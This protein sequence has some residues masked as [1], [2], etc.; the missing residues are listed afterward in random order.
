MKGRNWKNILLVSAFF[1]GKV[2]DN[3]MKSYYITGEIL[4]AA[5]H[6][7]RIETVQLPGQRD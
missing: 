7:Q 4:N 1:N 3:S 6:I 2:I 5:Y